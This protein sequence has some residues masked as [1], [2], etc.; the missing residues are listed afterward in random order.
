MT[1]TDPPP[2]AADSPE[3]DNRR[4]GLA[5]IWMPGLL[6]SVGAAVATAHGLY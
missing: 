4:T 1:P 6:V 3:Q 2:L 5:A